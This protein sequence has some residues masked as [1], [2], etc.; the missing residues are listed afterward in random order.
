MWTQLLLA[1][2]AC[3]LPTRIEALHIPAATAALSS[4][5]QA[6]IFVRSPRLPHGA[7]A[8]PSQGALTQAQ[9]QNLKLTTLAMTKRTSQWRRQHGAWQASKPKVR[10]SLN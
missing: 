6:G 1:L 10:R 7:P 8:N 5:R 9:T 3:C 2:A 4:S